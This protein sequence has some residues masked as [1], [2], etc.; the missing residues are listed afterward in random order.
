[1]SNCCTIDEIRN[2]S[3]YEGLG[4][5]A[6]MTEKGLGSY[7]DSIMECQHG[8]LF[9]LNMTFFNEDDT[10]EVFC[11]P[12]GIKDLRDVISRKNREIRELNKEL[13]GEG[14]LNTQCQ[15]C[16]KCFKGFIYETCSCGKPIGTSMEMYRSWF[17]R[18]NKRMEAIRY[19][20]PKLYTDSMK[21][22]VVDELK[23]YIDGYWKLDFK[24]SKVELIDAKE[25]IPETINPRGHVSYFGQIKGQPMGIKLTAKYKDV[26]VLIS[27]DTS[28]KNSHYGRILSND[29][30]SAGQLLY[31][32][33]NLWDLRKFIREI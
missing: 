10:E 30:A 24:E 18:V 4:A 28:A 17:F 23:I 26:R 33:T 31:E 7:E 12:I 3:V 13:A 6:T 8:N 21:V 20:R 16:L 5:N 19:C 2:A 32:T 25:D 29:Q 1:M 27:V 22:H 11:D 15:N 9:M 14:L